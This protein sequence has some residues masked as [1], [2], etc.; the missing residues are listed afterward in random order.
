MPVL[1][2]HFITPAV[3]SRQMPEEAAT[4]LS[5]LEKKVLLTL[6]ETGKATPDE[7][8]NVGKFK[9]LVEV[10]NASSW[11]QAKGLV[12]VKERVVRYYGLARKQWA[13]RNLPERVLLKALNKTRGSAT[14][15][16]LKERS[17]LDEKDFTIAL[18]WMKRKGW[19]AIEKALGE[20]KV[21]LADRGRVALTSKEADEAL[22]RDLGKGE[23]P[24]EAIDPQVLRMLKGRQEILRE[25]EVVRRE[26]SL[27]S[28]GEAVLRMGVEL[29]EEV[30]QLTPSLLATGKWRKV[31]IRPYDVNAFAPSVYPGKRHPLARYIDR[32]RQIFLRMGFVEMTGDFVQP[33]FWVY[34]AL[35]QPQDHPARDMLDTFHLEGAGTMRLPD[36]LLVSRISEV[37]R[38]GGDTGSA[39]WGYEWQRS[40]AEKAVLRSHT[41]PLSVQYLFAHPSPPVR[42]FS[43]GRCFRRDALDA[44]HLP[45]F[46]QVEGIIMEEGASLGML[47]GTI[48]EFYR[49]MGAEGVR[50]RPGYF[51]YTEPSLEPEVL[52]GG[53]WMELGGAGI[54]RPE[55]TAPLG[56]KHPVLAWGLGLERL[57]M[58]LEGIRDIRDLYL[59]DMDWLRKHPLRP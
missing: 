26:I 20:T 55:V 23:L 33:S 1:R 52:F 19:A 53:E 40:E 36:D 13:T 44:T 17:G 38:S 45:E 46:H 28:E 14:L 15:E 32:V 24:E 57:V 29:K 16:E 27:T 10:M 8:L 58:S 18:G 41:T 34:D 42:A 5:Y 39:G 22:L 12:L 49:Q 9:E 6:R 59:S 48:K 56:V 47:I 3:Y 7:I 35:F 31:E 51:P 2:K 11:L 25:K 21:T 4:R 50:V 54:F 30:A 43:V 37:H